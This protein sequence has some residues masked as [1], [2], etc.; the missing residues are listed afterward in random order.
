[1]VEVAKKVFECD[2]CGEK[3]EEGEIVTE[4]RDILSR[5]SA[6]EPFPAG[7]C[8]SCGSLVHEADRD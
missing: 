2:N 4:I 8:P 3:W 6:G 1:M 5:V 7:E